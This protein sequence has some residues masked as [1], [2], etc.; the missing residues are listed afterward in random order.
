M[1]DKCNRTMVMDEQFLANKKEKLH[2]LFNKKDDKIKY[3]TIETMDL[4]QGIIE[5]K[6]KKQA[7]VFNMDNDPLK[8]IVL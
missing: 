7:M 3:Q 2:P 8:F 4:Y 5:L 6:P 1:R